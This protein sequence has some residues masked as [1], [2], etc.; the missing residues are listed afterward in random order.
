MPIFIYNSLTRKKEE[1]IPLSHPKVNIYTCG[2]TVYDDSHIGHARSLY[3]F[4]VIRRYLEYRGF[5]VKFVRNITDVDDKIINRANE[6]KVEWQELVKK[7]IGRYY[8]DLEA[9]GIKKG[10]FEPRATENI[11][12][13]VK[14]IQTLVDKGYAYEAG[15]DVYFNVRKFPDYGKLSGQSINQME[16][17]VRIGPSELKHDPL[18]FALWKKSKEGEPFWD[19][20]WSQGRPGWHIECSVMSQKFLKTDTLD[21]HAGG[22]DLIFPHHENE[23]AQAEALTGK[24]FAKYWIHHGLLTINGQKMSKSLGNFFTIDDV[25][26]RYSADVLKVCC[27]TVHYANPLDF[28]WERMDGAKEELERVRECIDRIN[29]YIEERNNGL[30]SSRPIIKYAD[31]KKDIDKLKMKFEDAMN[32]DFNTPQAK[33]VI[34]QVVTKFYIDNLRLENIECLDYVKKAI[35]ELGNV[36]GLTFERMEAIDPELAAMIEERNR[37]RKENDFK[38]ADSIRKELEAKGIILE[39]TK[40]GRSGWH[41]KL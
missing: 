9:L 25:L 5:D 16:T 7:Y 10:D 28:S 18:D 37:A 35:I 15:G 26:K 34:L 30:L 14:Y 17:G 40:Y 11:T 23:I 12:D 21:I 6:L 13:M 36:L 31:F 8:E 4:D 33:S 27:L 39:D 32:D 3:I 22:R 29:Y 24:Q 20:P 19:S 41:R 38:K 1:F 2:V